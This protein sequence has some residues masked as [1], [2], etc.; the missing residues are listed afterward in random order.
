[1]KPIKCIA[2]G[3]DKL[4]PIWNTSNVCRNCRCVANRLL[5]N[6]FTTLETF[7]VLMYNKAFSRNY[8]NNKKKVITK[9]DSTT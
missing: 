8:K 1:M 9:I 7:I 5:E 4:G 6:G 2:C 3:R